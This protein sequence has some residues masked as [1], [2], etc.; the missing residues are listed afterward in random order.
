M[1]MKDVSKSPDG[2]W[3]P[4]GENYVT[5]VLEVGLSE[6]FHHLVLDA[7]IWLESPGSHATQVVLMDIDPNQPRITIKKWE[8]VAFRSTRSGQLAKPRMTQEVQVSLI[9]NVPT[10]SGSLELSFA[11]LFDRPPARKTQEADISFSPHDLTR[12]AKIVWKQQDA[13]RQEKAAK[14]NTTSST[15]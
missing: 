7:H 12:I 5:C 10:A 13:I 11:K 15:R 9:D 6:S 2:S 4:F 1:N 3:A 14:T 8:I